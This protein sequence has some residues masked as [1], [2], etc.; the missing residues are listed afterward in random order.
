MIFLNIFIL[1]FY[2][3]FS[4][5]YNLKVKKIYNYINNWYNYNIIIHIIIFFFLKYELLS[6]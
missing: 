4:N 5:I 3:Y 2:N 1:K 6:N